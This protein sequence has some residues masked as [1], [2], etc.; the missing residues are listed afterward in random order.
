[1]PAPKATGTQGNSRP[2]PASSRAQLLNLAAKDGHAS[3]PITG[4]P[5]AS[6]PRGGQTS[7]TTPASPR[8]HPGGL[9]GSAIPHH[10]ATAR[11]SRLSEPLGIRL[12]ERNGNP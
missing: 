2:A 11:A 8:R 1:M 4:T 7:A 9:P 5:P 12:A 3:E 6:A 10:P